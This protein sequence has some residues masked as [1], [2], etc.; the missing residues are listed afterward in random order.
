M[1][2]IKCEACYHY[3]SDKATS[4]PKCGHPVDP[5]HVTKSLKTIQDN[6]KKRIRSRL[7][8]WS[9]VAGVLILLI[10]TCDISGSNVERKPTVYGSGT[11]DLLYA[12]S[13]TTDQVKE[14]L[15]SPST[16]SF[17]ET[18]ERVEHTEYVGNNT[19][20]IT[21][22]VDSQ[23]S[24]GAELRNRFTAKIKFENGEYRVYDVAFE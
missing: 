13:L 1:A 15:K 4:C 7:L 8:G 20:I 5:A 17:A 23:N 2:L 9:I 18:R 19:Y 16:A 3:I 11:T 6:N 22:Y 10:Y 21:S 14:Y 24:F 12:Y